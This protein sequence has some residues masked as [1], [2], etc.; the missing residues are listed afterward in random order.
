VLL[1][2]AAADLHELERERRARAA[3][4][5]DVRRGLT[6][7]PKRLPSHLLYDDVG[8]LLYERITAL[9]EY[10]LWRAERAIFEEGA[11]EIVAYARGAAD[12]LEVVELGAGNASKTQ[13]LL[14]EV[15]GQKAAC[16]Y[17]P[18]DVSASAI[19][20]AQR[21]LNARLPRV[22]VRP[23][24]MPY[25]Q[26]L[27]ALS[28]SATAPR[29]VLFIGSSVGNLDDAEASSLLEGVRRVSRENTS[30][31]LGTDLRKS[32]SVLLPAYDDAA[33]IT[34]AF[35]KNILA[36]I[37]R[38]LGG[39]FEMDRFRH[40]ARWNGAASRVEMHLE[41]TA[42]QEVNIE[43][44]ALRVRFA[45]G[46]TIHTESSVKYDLPRVERLLARGGFAHERTL[47][48]RARTFAVHLARAA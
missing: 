8:S 29:L 35:N 42:H 5:D 45:R 34:A 37:N 32:P 10:Y 40:V 4:A 20:D 28:G 19:R 3:I 11:P 18:I 41:S 14:E 15:L 26:A 6:A 36:R 33:G 21:T 22:H 39:R 43:G 47:F 9:P 1:S 25:D 27:R 17:V 2:R 44:L 23:V 48:D 12:A 38:E 31:L 24:T 13:I 46:E 7:S 30:L 16:D